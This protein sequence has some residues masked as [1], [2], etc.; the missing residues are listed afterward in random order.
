MD[1]NYYDILGLNRDATAEEIKKAYRKLSKTYHPDVN[2]DL[3]ASDKFQ[4]I[5]KAYSVL[6]DEDQKYIYDQ[7]LN[8][9]ETSNRG[10]EVPQYSNIF[11]THKDL[12]TPR[13]GAD[14]EA[15][16]SITDVEAYTGT[17]KNVTIE[18]QSKC[19]HC[20]GSGVVKDEDAG[21]CITCNGTKK[22]TI[23]TKNP[24]GAVAKTTRTCPDCKHQ[25]SQETQ[26]TECSG[27]GLAKDLVVVTVDIPPKI[28]DNTRVVV[29]GFGF[30][31]RHG[32]EKGDLLVLVKVQKSA[33]YVVD[34][35]DLVFEVDV[36]YSKLVLGGEVQVQTPIGLETITIKPRTKPITEMRIRGRGLQ[37]SKTKTLGDLVFK[38]N[39]HI[40]DSLTIE[41]ENIIR[42]L[43]A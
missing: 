6:S 34:G 21:T 24:F 25:S 26:C 17:T 12:R 31:G 42:S 20:N 4:E 30:D 29:K 16:V 5:S 27:T 19:T 35:I 2:K 28:K 14:R 15:S 40:P 39:L 22:I 10:D 1:K 32:G 7:E 3:D 9:S 8:K 33:N 23:E 36:P 18:V 41:Q 43:D 37:D 11:S 38:I 13:K